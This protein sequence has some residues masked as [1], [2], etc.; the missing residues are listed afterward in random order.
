MSNGWHILRE[1]NRYVLA[2]R[3]PVRFDIEAVSEFPP[4][5][6]SRLAR[7]VRQ[8]VWRMLKGLRGFSPV[9]EVTL[10]QVGVI[11]RAGGQV[12]DGAAVPPNA[13][14]DLKDL[15]SDPSHRA[16]WSKWAGKRRRGRA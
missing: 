13:N 16:R 6:P 11:V 2:R 14:Q 9:V 10:D 7:Q 4:L 8:D 3:L 5:D 15:L 1:D 12:A